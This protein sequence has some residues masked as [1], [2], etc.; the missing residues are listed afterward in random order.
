MSTTYYFT[1]VKYFRGHTRHLRHDQLSLALIWM[2][3][4]RTRTDRYEV[5]KKRE[6]KLIF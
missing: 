6:C 4:V 3:E 5:E 2:G 1:C